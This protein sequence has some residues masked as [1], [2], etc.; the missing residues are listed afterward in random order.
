[1]AIHAACKRAG[2]SRLA[3]AGSSDGVGKMRSC[4]SWGDTCVI[5]SGGMHGCY[6]IADEKT[7][8][9]GRR[10]VP[11]SFSIHD[12]ALQIRFAAAVARRIVAAPSNMDPFH[13]NERQLFPGFARSR[14]LLDMLDEGARLVADRT[15]LTRS[16]RNR[17]EERQMSKHM[18][19]IVFVTLACTSLALL[20]LSEMEQVMRYS[21]DQIVTTSVYTQLDSQFTEWYYG[22]SWPR[23]ARRA[24]ARSKYN[25][26]RFP[27][28]A[29]AMHATIISLVRTPGR[30]KDLCDSLE[31]GGMAYTM[32]PAQDGLEAFP[33][34]MV[35]WYAGDRRKRLLKRF[36]LTSAADP[37]IYAAYKDHASVP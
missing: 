27:T 21:R 24:R 14:A 31:A 35:D 22:V 3:S 7:S 29:A 5:A 25:C 26:T 10:I 2:L 9:S 1:V 19:V 12:D 23:I 20:P 17:P 32:F 8:V 37:A 36:P 16:S 15:T 30:A 6:A 4:G 34:E 18:V 13:V 11:T 33:K 28:D